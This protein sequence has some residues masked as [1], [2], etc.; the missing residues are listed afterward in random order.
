[1]KKENQLILDQK[2]FDGVFLGQ[3]AQNWVKMPFL[4]ILTPKNIEKYFFNKKLIDFSFWWY[5][6]APYFFV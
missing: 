2:K 3:N 5:F 4:R 6:S 1:M